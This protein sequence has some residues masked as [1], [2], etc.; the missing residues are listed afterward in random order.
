MSWSFDAEDPLTPSLYGSRDGL[1]A[2]GTKGFWSVVLQRF[3]PLHNILIQFSDRTII[4]NV[5]I[6]E[7]HRHVYILWRYNAEIV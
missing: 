4:R 3:D 7:E 5:L 6:S 1:G 2:L